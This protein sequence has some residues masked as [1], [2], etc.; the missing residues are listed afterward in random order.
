MRAVVAILGTLSWFATACGG[1]GGGDRRRRHDADAAVTPDAYIVGADVTTD[2]GPV[3]GVVDG[4]LVAFRGIPYA[5]P[6]IGARRFAPPAP[7]APWTAPLDAIAVRPGVPAD[8]QHP[9]RTAERRLPDDQRVGARRAPAPRPVIVWVHGGGYVAG[10][11]REP[12]YDGATLATHLRCRRSCPS[13]T[14]SACSASSRCRAR[15]DRRRQRQL[16]PAR[17]D[18][19]ARVGEAQHRGVRR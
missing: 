2:S 10:S 6:P 9:R 12:L 3:H 17:S 14:G 1:G 7:P 18:R 11:S 5:A 15:G 19:G 13:T 16:G 4:T 8:R